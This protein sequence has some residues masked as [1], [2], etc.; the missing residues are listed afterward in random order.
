MEA[1]TNKHL[2][3][4]RASETATAT[5]FIR[6]LASH[7]EREEVKGPDYLAKIFLTKAQQA[8]LKKPEV[9]KWVLKNK[10]DHGAYE[11]MIARTAFFDYAVQQALRRNIP[12]IVF[13]GAGYD[14]RP[15]RFKD[16]IQ[17]TR[18]F[19][20]DA[21]P[22]QQRKKEILHQASV[23]IPQQAVFVPINFE[24]DSLKDVLIGAGFNPDQ[25]SLFVWEGVTYYLSAE[26]VDSTLNFI[27]FNSPRG[28][29]ICFDY[30]SLSPGAFNDSGVKKIRERMK[31]RYSSEPTRFGITQGKLDLFLSERGYRIIDH[32][33]S[34]DM[35]CRY[36]TLHDGSSIGRVPPLFCLVYA[37]VSTQTL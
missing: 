24:T 25:K 19:E 35:E 34:N 20:L 5:A 18:I 27:R 26:A 29:S 7:D 15:Y 9:I 14:T 8:V 33:T 4:Y 21:Q 10:I 11:F 36:L 28:S 12:Q 6:A 37:E 17:S 1:D 32:L 31:S 3:K 30:A 2:I 22:T 16:V 13:L 23:Y